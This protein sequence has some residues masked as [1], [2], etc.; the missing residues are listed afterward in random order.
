MNPRTAANREPFSLVAEEFNEFL[1]RI[2]TRFTRWARSGNLHF[3]HRVGRIEH[4]LSASV[5]KHTAKKG[6]DAPER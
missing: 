6:L 1:K 3:P 4:T 2:G 5:T